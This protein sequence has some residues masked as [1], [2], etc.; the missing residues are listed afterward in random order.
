[1]ILAD[2]SVLPGA[3]SPFTQH[4]QTVTT[5]ATLITRATK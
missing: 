3:S 5:S 2:R 1:V 4:A